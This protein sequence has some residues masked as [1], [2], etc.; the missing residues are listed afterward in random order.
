MQGLWVRGEVFGTLATG[1]PRSKKQVK[2]ILAAN[3]HDV[4]LEATSLLGR[5]YDGPVDQAPNGKYSFV[6]P[7][8][9]RDRRFY[10]TLTV[11]NGTYKVV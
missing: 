6:G 8:P 7:D 2:A 10:G 9:Y 5:E 11:F 4:A 1:R 3:P